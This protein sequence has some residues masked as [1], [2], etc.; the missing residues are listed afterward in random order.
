MTCGGN[1]ADDERMNRSLAAFAASAWLR[2]RVRIAWCMV[3]TAVYQ[4]G[5]TSSSQAKK[6]S[7]LK[8]GV[9]LTDA[10][11]PSDDSTGAKRPF[12]NTTN[13][14]V[15]PNVYGSSAAA[16]S[17]PTARF[18]A[19]MNGVFA[20]DD[21]LVYF[22]SSLRVVGKPRRANASAPAARTAV[23]GAGAWSDAE[24]ANALACSWKLTV[25]LSVVLTEALTPPPTPS[26]I[27]GLRAP[28]RATCRPTSRC[29]HRPARARNRAR[30][31]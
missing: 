18:C 8:P 15:P 12:R 24:A 31:S 30:C 21:T 26:R 19:A 16:S 7:A 13:G 25:R 27:R 11:A 3:G 28:A 6:R 29:G 2:R 17:V 1:E 9:Q 14:Q 5:F 10:P 20:I 23:S 22:Q 4:V